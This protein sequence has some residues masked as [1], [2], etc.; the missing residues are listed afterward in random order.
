MKSNLL[1]LSIILAIVMAS[2]EKEPGIPPSNLKDLNV[3]ADFSWSNTQLNEM[4]VS[5]TNANGMATEGRVMKLMDDE[6]RIIEQGVVKSGK[7][8]F[9]AETA[10]STEMLSL[11][12]PMTRDKMEI[13]NSAGNRNITFPLTS[14]SVGPIIK[15]M[16]ISPSCD[17]GCTKVFTGNLTNIE[18]KT[19]G[20]FCLTGNLNGG[21]TITSNATLRICGN[22]NITWTNFGSKK[23][24]N[25]I[26]TSTG[27]ITSGGFYL[28]GANHSL[29]NYGTISIT[30]WYDV[31][32]SLQNF[33]VME[34]NGL[35]I[36]KNGA[37]TNSGKFTTNGET[38][39]SGS[40][41]NSDNFTIAG[42]TNSLNISTGGR[43]E[44]SCQLSVPRNLNN[45]GSIQNNGYIRVA[46]FF[47]GESSGTVVLGNQAMLHCM[48][49]QP[50][51][52]ISC[53]DPT[54]FGSIKV[55]AVT[56]LDSKTTFSGHI[57]ICD[58]NGIDN[59]WGATIGSNVTYCEGY[60]PVT[61]CNPEGIGAPK[62]ADAD[63][64]GI[65]DDEDQFPDDPKRAFKFAEPYE[66]YKI[67]A[68]EDLWPSIGDY[69]FND[70]VLA[71]RIVYIL[72]PDQKPVEAE[73][74]VVI[75]ALG[76]GISNGLGLQ[77]LGEKVSTVKIISSIAG[78]SVSIDPAT[79]TT[80]IISNDIKASLKPF[81][82]NNG[83]GP[84]GDPQSI[85]FTVTFDQSVLPENAGLYGDFFLYR[86][87]DRTRE[88][89]MP[90]KPSTIAASKDFF[91]TYNDATHPDESYWYKTPNGIPWGM[92]LMTL[93]EEWHNPIEKISI[94]QAYPE[95]R[96]WAVSGGMQN[97][98][99]HRHGVYEK[100]FHF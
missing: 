55:D 43:L 52:A 36:T 67:W 33:G 98:E 8:K 97:Q 3:P 65:V 1:F 32:K 37:M 85:S 91:G 51:C 44:N 24:I 88:I 63:G 62:I 99:W 29:E 71:T 39:I 60:I 94:L 12:F 17:E 23:N 59:N 61:S 20:I 9:H 27:S 5:L 86:T 16:N 92:T 73:A 50:N 57:D 11:Y 81:Y 46:N 80:L 72:G 31:N 64:D 42:S 89:H 28:D 48:N 83:T 87:A 47:Y 22:A 21:L 84:K 58:A 74:E 96:D 54:G 19:E 76:A 56:N 40:L 77:F 7:V 38:N 69:D 45:Q 68:F 100:C 25:I 75:K 2:C 66:G 35:E 18:I 49:F 6:G 79:G 90:D 30:N 34:V 4:V 26:V 10:T 70:L 82:N 53:S 14:V 41:I 15:S 13:P 95:F 78:G 93:D